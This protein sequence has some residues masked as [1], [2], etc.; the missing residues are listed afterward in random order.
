MPTQ[1]TSSSAC[2]AAGARAQ[3]HRCQHQFDHRYQRHEPAAQRQRLQRFRLDHPSQQLACALMANL[4]RLQA[5]RAAQQPFL[6]DSAGGDRD[7][8]LQPGD[9]AADGNQ[10]QQQQGP[11]QQQAAIEA[12]FESAHADNEPRRQPEH[13]LNQMCAGQHGK[14]P[15]NPR[16]FQLQGEAGAWRKP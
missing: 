11:R 13:V 1:S 4:V 6:Q 3:H 10:R 15:R 8:S 2:P 14:P 12:P 7:Q 5:Q 9:E 16:Q